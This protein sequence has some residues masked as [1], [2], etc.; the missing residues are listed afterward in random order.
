MKPKVVIRSRNKTAAEGTYKAFLRAKA[1]A[2]QL[3]MKYTK[4]VITFQRQ[5][6]VPKYDQ[7]YDLT[8]HC[9]SLINIH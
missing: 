4:E 7:V 2:D 5:D 6:L 9:N 1:Y 8:D 3:K